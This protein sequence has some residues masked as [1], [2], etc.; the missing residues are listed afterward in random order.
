[1]KDERLRSNQPG[2][3]SDEDVASW[4]EHPTTQTVRVFLQRRVREIQEGWS[5]GE[6]ISDPLRNA[7]ALSACQTIEGFLSLTADEI[8]QGMSDE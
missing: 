5:K 2:L 6:F 3:L 7:Q 4:W 1:M 8:N